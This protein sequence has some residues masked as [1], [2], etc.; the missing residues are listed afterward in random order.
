MGIVEPTW[1]DVVSTLLHGA[2]LT[3]QQATWAWERI[4]RGEARPAQI[5]GFVVA[6]R[7][8]GET[9]GEL[10]ALAEE[11]LRHAHRIEVPGPSLD[12]VGTGGDQAHTVNISTMAAIVCAAAGAT[13]VKHGNRAASSRSGTADVLEALGIHVTLT[14]DQVVDV[15]CRAG[16][17]LC[18]A[19]VFHPA[20]RHAAQT[21]RDLGVPTVFNV[22][23]PLT[24]PAQP[25]CSAIG[26]ADARLAPLVAGVFASRG[27]AAVVFRGD[28]GLDELTLSTSSQFWW[29]QQG[30][31]I[32]GSIT[33]EDLGLSRAPLSALRGGDPQHNAT[34]V[35]DLVSGVR[36][37]V[38]DAVVLNAGAA[39]ATLPKSGT[40][41]PELSSQ[42]ELMRRL[43]AGMDQAEEA[44]DSGAAQQR[45]AL[46][47]EVSRE[48]L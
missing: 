33:P 22:L 3:T 34:V 1:P 39:L 23:G 24:N 20:M 21:R 27:R 14:P 13:V 32:T 19:Q 15:A 9:V 7:A 31:V 42:P 16:I 25:T 17:T 36:G 44:L 10:T 48:Y 8:K 26:V 37:P 30:Q 40:T 46:W 12:I 5:A 38:R 4:M 47:R 41:G 11:M 45:L 2:D 18:F 43:R 29:V 6:L 28:D 35:H